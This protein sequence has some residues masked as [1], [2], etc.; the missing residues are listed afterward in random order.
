MKKITST[1]VAGLLLVTGVAAAPANAAAGDTIN[2]VLGT[3]N[4]VVNWNFNMLGCRNV[5]SQAAHD[6]ALIS[7][8]SKLTLPVVKN[9]VFRGVPQTG[10]CYGNTYAFKY[11]N[12]KTVVNTRTCTDPYRVG[13]VDSIWSKMKGKSTCRLISTVGQI[14]LAHA[15]WNQNVTVSAGTAGNI[16]VVVK[17]ANN[18][19]WVASFTLDTYINP[20]GVSTSKSTFVK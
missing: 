7:N 3:A 16:G 17:G 9:V 11:S 10:A 1:V 2:N 6:Y 12:V 8:Q 4:T 19:D 18:I 5:I 15:G 20:F 13:L 14:S